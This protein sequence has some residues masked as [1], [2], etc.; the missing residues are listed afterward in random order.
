MNY[1]PWVEG[2]Y[3]AIY[4]VGWNSEFHAWQ[5]KSSYVVRNLWLFIYIYCPI[6]PYLNLYCSYILSHP[7][8]SQLLLFIYIVPSHHIS[9]ST[10]HVHCPI[11]PYLNFYCSYT[12]S[13]PT[14]STVHI[15]CP[16]PPY[17]NFYSSY[18][19]SHPTISQLLLFI[20]IIDDKLYSNMTQTFL[21]I[22]A[23]SQ[24]LSPLLP[25]LISP[26]WQK[27]GLWLNYVRIL[28][29][30]FLWVA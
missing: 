23:K 22:F 26:S 1:V 3:I 27:L 9:T 30:M 18:T 11:P 20:Y 21:L 13:H 16:I 10:V 5:N 14:I 15:H 19:L 28:L 7:A 8:I 2:I 6:P 12:L 25:L 24:Y 29:I 4:T 17:L